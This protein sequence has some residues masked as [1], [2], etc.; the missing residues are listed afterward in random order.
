MKKIILILLIIFFLGFTCS[1]KITEFESNPSGADT[2]NEWIEFYNEDEINLDGYKIVNNDGDEIKLSG[3]FK[4][5]FVYS[6]EKQW[7]DNSDEK[8]YLYHKDEL[9][10]ETDI[11]E[12]S[13][14]DDLTWS[15]CDSWEFKPSTKAQENSCHIKE[16][17]KEEESKEEVVV[18][19]NKTIETKKE[20]NTTPI[21]NE[22]I[23]L[24]PKDIKNTNNIEKTSKKN[25]AI[26]TLGLFCFL[27]AGLFTIKIYREKRN[28]LE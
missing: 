25:Y 7:L 19:E 2:G 18:I 14:N 8:V 6:F 28:G 23:S 17:E 3:S 9:I 16:E 13:S 15:L 24:N 27:L 10:D 22:I 5:Y 1:L 26:Y 12:D 20:K 11:F 21:E 4:D